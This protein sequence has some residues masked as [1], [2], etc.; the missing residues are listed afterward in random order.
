MI[1]RPPRSTL[2]SSS[3]AS[4][5]YKRQVDL[6]RSIVVS[7]DTFYYV[8]ASETDIDDTAR[9]LTQLG[10]GQKTGVD[11]EGELT[12]VLPSREW[13]RTRFAGANYRDEHRKWY[14]GDSISA[15]IGQGYNS[16]TP[17]QLAHAIAIIANDGVAF[18]PHLVKNIVNLKTGEERSVAPEPTHTLA[19]KPEY[20]AF[21]K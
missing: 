14:L 20:I 7:C 10:F 21:I 5:V 19:T 15:G 3:A 11:I 6:Y 13:K 2:S 4:D 9:F 17:M 16:F 12:G 18:R 1:R 8:L